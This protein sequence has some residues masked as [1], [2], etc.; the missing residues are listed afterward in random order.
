VAAVVAGYS[1]AL[2]PAA[3]P[4]AALAGIAL[5]VALLRAAAIVPWALALLAG[6]YAFALVRSDADLDARAGF[7]AAGLLLAGELAFWSAEARAWPREDSAA[8]RARLAGIVV[9]TLAAATLG[10]L[11]AA[12]GAAVPAGAR[13]LQLAGALGAVGVL[14]ALA[15]L[16]RPRN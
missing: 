9:L 11:L 12:A 10:T 7:V 6:A 15:L 3:L 13:L 14:L 1:A 2:D 5:A 16:A 4:L 8:A